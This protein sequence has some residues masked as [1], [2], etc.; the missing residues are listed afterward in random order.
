[1][2]PLNEETWKQY[3]VMLINYK[4]FF[5]HQ[6]TVP[7]GLYL[8]SEDFYE[9]I[10]NVQNLSEFSARCEHL[11]TMKNG[12][13]VRNA[14]VKLLKYLK[15]NAES[16]NKRDAYDVCELLNYWLI[17]RLSAN[18]GYNDKEQTIDAFAAIAN[19]WNEFTS[20]VLKKPYHESC[21]PLM[22]IIGLRDWRQRKDVYEYYVNYEY[23]KGMSRIQKSHKGYCTY[24][25]N[26]V[27]LYSYFD[28]TCKSDETQFCTVFQT[29]YKDCDP[30]NLLLDFQCEEE[31]NMR[32]LEA[33]PDLQLHEDTYL[34]GKI[35][36]IK[37][38][39]SGLTIEGTQTVKVL[40]STSNSLI[41]LKKA[42]GVLMGIVAISMIYGFL[43]KFKPLGFWINKR[44]A[45][46]NYSRIN[47]ISEFNDAFDYAQES[48][49]PYYIFKDEHYIGYHTD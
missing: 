38:Q 8:T 29:K 23:L 22:S 44:F 40:Q 35:S 27:S 42:G 21:N 4:H 14:C 47:V 26:K 3:D 15:Y 34:Q 11:R 41:P 45:N 16:L 19:I 12:M 18:V 17:A 49:N 1:M 46:K 30:H 36:E 6:L 2:I 48:H 32:M 28:H 33:S 5:L 37:I 7:F 39:P 9:R 13:N 20:D 24:I 31:M 43:H 10:E 25:R